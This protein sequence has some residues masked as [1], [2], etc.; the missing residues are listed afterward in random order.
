M[1]QL[2]I[3]A[4]TLRIRMHGADTGIDQ[5]IDRFV[6]L[7]EFNVVNGR[8]MGEGIFHR[9]VVVIQ[10]RFIRIG[11]QLLIVVCV[12][13]DR[14]QFFS[15]IGSQVESGAF[16]MVGDDDG[17]PIDPFRGI[18]R[19]FRIDAEHAVGQLDGRE[20]RNQQVA[21]VTDVRIDIIY[22]IFLCVG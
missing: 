11:S 8:L 9:Q 13:T 3:P 22:I 15:L 6:G 19:P 10:F 16:T 2:L 14:L 21:D 17:K 20:S 5:D 7:S 18:V 1:A 12:G 4:D